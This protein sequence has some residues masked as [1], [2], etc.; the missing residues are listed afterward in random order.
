MT[1]SRPGWPLPLFLL[2]LLLL[3]PPLL[4]TSGRIGYAPVTFPGITEALQAGNTTLAAEWVKKTAD[5]IQV[6]ADILKP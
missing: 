2:L 3:P 5:A 6:A 1:H 4:T